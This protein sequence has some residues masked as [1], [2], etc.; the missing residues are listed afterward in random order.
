MSKQRQQLAVYRDMYLRIFDG[1]CVR[2]GKPTKTLHEIIP[3]S[4]GAKSLAG[5]NR[6]PLCTQ[7]HSWAHDVGTKI[8]IP[9]L[10]EERNEFLRRKWQ[11]RGEKVK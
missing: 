7:C 5:K 6:V 11:G 3:I 8:S 9:I 4:H 1:R 2:C 10:Q